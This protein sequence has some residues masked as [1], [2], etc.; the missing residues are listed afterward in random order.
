MLRHAAKEEGITLNS[1]GFANLDAVLKHK[2]F[3]KWTVKDV[4]TLIEKHDRKRFTMDTDDVTGKLRIKANDFHSMD[5][6]F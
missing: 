1:E 5:V 4:E 3:I 2:S 6:G